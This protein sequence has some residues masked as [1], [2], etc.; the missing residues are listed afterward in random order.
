MT[1]VFHWR[2]GASDLQFAADL[3]NRTPKKALNGRTPYTSFLGKSASLKYIKRFGCEA[4]ALRTSKMNEFEERT[5]TGY[6]LRCNEDSYNI[7]EPTSG[8]V[9]KTKNADFHEN[10]TYGDVFNK[11]ANKKETV[12]ENR[13][14]GGS[15]EGSEWFEEPKMDNNNEGSIPECITSPSA[16]LIDLSKAETVWFDYFNKNVNE[17]IEMFSL[18]YEPRTY[19][20]A[21]FGL[22]SEN[23]KTAISEELD[24]PKKNNTRSL[25]VLNNPKIKRTE[26][27]TSK[28]D[29]KIKDEPEGKR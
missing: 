12:F 17:V 3:Y 1:V 21:I 22:D 29:F 18:E 6:L 23:W 16:P 13:K 2:C 26:I 19:E 7:I 11:L 24:S 9:W 10:K 5:L 8:K 15:E 4:Y 28:W 20:Q 25:V 14:V 27:I